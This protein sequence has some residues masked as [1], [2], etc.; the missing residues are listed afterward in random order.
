M[1]FVF[2]LKLGS[3][4]WSK[5][6]TSVPRR[7][8]RQ[9]PTY[10]FFIYV[11]I[12]TLLNSACPM[13]ISQAWLGLA[14]AGRLTGQGDMP[15]TLSTTQ[16]VHPLPTSGTVPGKSQFIHANT[17]ILVPKAGRQAENI[18]S[19]GQFP[20][21]LCVPISVITLIAQDLAPLLSSLRLGLPE[22]RLQCTELRRLAEEPEQPGLGVGPILCVQPGAWISHIELFS[23]SLPLHCVSLLAHLAKPMLACS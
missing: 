19:Q 7:T 8:I 20:E 10:T 2:L 3:F 15:C 17:V 18:T 16:S 1:T 11:C 12:P 21:S 5:C 14:G 9:S 6:L 23:P 22:G 13:T 4:S